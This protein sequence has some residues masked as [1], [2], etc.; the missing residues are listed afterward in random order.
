MKILVVLFLWYLKINQF[1]RYPNPVTGS[2]DTPYH[3]D[4]GRKPI[5]KVNKLESL[6]PCLYRHHPLIYC[7]CRRFNFFISIILESLG[8][9]LQALYQH[10]GGTS[11][12]HFAFFLLHAARLLTREYG[13]LNLW[14][15]SQVA[16][17]A[18]KVLQVIHYERESNYGRS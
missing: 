17:L 15:Y 8:T 4:T 3:A 11:L 18:K 5:E 7:S 16:Q 10:T 12:L 6:L 9:Q 2:N 1:I 14:A 13:K